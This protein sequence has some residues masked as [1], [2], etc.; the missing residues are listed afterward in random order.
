MVKKTVLI[1]RLKEAVKQDN[2]AGQLVLC[3]TTKETSAK[4]KE[5]AK[6]TRKPCK[7]GSTTHPVHHLEPALYINGN[8]P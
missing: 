8:Y 1:A 7:C 2:Y 4:E 6:S 5:K 3:E